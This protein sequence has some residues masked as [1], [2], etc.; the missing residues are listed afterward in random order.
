MP[1]SFDSICC[2]CKCEH[3]MCLS[4]IV[5]EKITELYQETGSVAEVVEYFQNS[6]LM[7]AVKDVAFQ[8]SA[9]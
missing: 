1:R 6:M 2:V 4:S 8:L 3:F 5:I 9:D 7:D